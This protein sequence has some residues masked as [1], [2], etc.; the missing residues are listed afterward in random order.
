MMMDLMI[1]PVNNS[2]HNF[3]VK[4]SLNEV[5]RITIMNRNTQNLK[6]SKF[7]LVEKD[8]QEQNQIMFIT[9]SEE[10]PKFPTYK[11]EN[12]SKIVQVQYYQ[13]DLPHHTDVI[14]SG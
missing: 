3:L 14:K 1:G 10:N 4:F 2:N 9:F 7:I 5:G 12:K 6:K 8:L 11:I 13:K